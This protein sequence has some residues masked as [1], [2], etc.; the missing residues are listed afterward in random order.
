MTVRIL[1]VDDHTLFRRG[2]VDLLHRTPG[3]SVVSEADD[4]RAAVDQARACWA[5]VVL[6]DMYMPGLNGWEATRQLLAE[7]PETRVLGLSAKGDTRSVARMLEMGASGY[8]LK[9]ATVDEMVGAIRSVARGEM[10]L[11]Q[12]LTAP[13][14]E[15]YVRGDGNGNGNGNGNGHDR[16]GGVSLSNR[17]REVLQLVAEGYSL[18]AIASELHVSVKTVE[19]HRASVMRKLELSSVADL[20]KYAIREGITELEV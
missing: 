1:V 12:G 15:H 20:T 8:M 4:G 19:T 17:E 11:G 14:V 7:T 6:M 13:I 3:M 9:T 2:L 5:H 10:V 18:K 16:H